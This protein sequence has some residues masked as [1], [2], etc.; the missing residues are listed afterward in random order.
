MKIARTAVLLM[1]GALAGCM[2][3]GPATTAQMPSEPRSPLGSPFARRQ[4]PL[5]TP[6]ILDRTDLRIGTTA[7]F[8]R[9]PT[10]QELNDLNQL[11]SLAHVVIS[12]PEWPEDLASL[13]ALGLLP[14]ECDVIVVMPGYPPN[15]AA[16][17]AWNYVT[18][19]LRIVLVVNGT[20]TTASVVGDLN[21][22]RHLERVIA[23]MDVPSR[24]GF[25]R[26]QRPV[27]FLKRYE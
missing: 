21:M 17:E 1:L 24:F 18:G 22:M 25:E 8:D 9:I 5:G 14:E 27:S 4:G 23:E 3:N 11:P 20:P 13:S 6:L 2:A 7:Q 15:R 16:A 19:R 10:A 26:L 12:L